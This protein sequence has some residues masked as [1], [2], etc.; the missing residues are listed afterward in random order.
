KKGFGITAV[1]DANGRL[2]GVISDGDLRRLLQKDE[3]ILRKTAGDSI[4]GNPS[5]IAADEMASAA[6]QL[7]E[8]RKI[9]SLFITDDDGRVQGI[10]HIHDLWGLELF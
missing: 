5:T 3:E 8:Q 6:L 7:M 9:T 4:K 1:V 10:I 2:L